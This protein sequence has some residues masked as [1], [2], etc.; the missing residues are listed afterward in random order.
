MVV[1]DMNMKYI[2]VD[3]KDIE[4]WRKFLNFDYWRSKLLGFL[5]RLVEILDFVVFVEAVVEVISRFFQSKL[6][7]FVENGR[8]PLSI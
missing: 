2:P 5:L 6:F 1:N 3:L 4:K 8:S 7:D